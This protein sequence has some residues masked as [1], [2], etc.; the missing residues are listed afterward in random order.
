[1]A[2]VKFPR[3]EPGL[4]IRYACLWAGEAARG[5]ADASKDRPRAV[6]L[7]VGGEGPTTLVRVL[8]ITHRPPADAV[9]ALEIPLATKR[10]LGLDGERSWV[11]LTEANEF[12]WPGPDLRPVRQ[13]EV[14]SFTCGLLPPRFFAVLKQRLSERRGRSVR[15]TE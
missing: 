11:V 13:S 3:P 12:G 5:R 15:R 7:V 9:D 14:L 1:M 6:I 4:V 10:R 2:A 8:P